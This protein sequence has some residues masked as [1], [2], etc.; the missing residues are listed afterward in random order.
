[1]YNL[2]PT[3]AGP[4]SR[5]HAHLDRIAAMGFDWIYLNPIHATGGSGSLYAVADYYRLNPRLRGDDPRGDDAIVAE[6]IAAA[7][8]HGLAVMLDLVI[9]H[10]ANDS[11]LVAEHPGWYAREADGSIAAP[12]AID[13]D[14]PENVTRWGDLAELDFSERPQR[15]EIV[16][17]FADVVRHYAGLGARGFRCDAA[18]KI[19]AAVWSDVI[20]AARERA[21]D[22]VFAAETL[23]ARLEEVAQLG[24]AGFDYLFNS[25]KWWDFRA[26]WLLEQYERFRHIAPSIAFPESHD[27]PRLAAELAGRGDAE[28]EAEYRFRYLFAAFFSSGVMMPMG[29]EFGFARK[30]DVVTTSPADW[31]DARFDLC[32]FI[33]AANALKADTPVL[34]E[35]GAERMLRGEGPAVTL[36]R[37][38]GASTGAAV[39]VFN[40]DASEPAEVDAR[41][42]IDALDGAPRDVTPQ[43]A[44]PRSTPDDRVSLQ[45]L[46]IRV[47]T[48]DEA[49]LDAAP[50]PRPDARAADRVVVIENVTPQI[51]GGRHPIKRIVGDRI[52][53]E[54]DVFRE[55][56]ASLAA[57]LLHRER[58]AAHWHETPLQPLGNDRWSG[59]FPVDRNAEY[60]YTI[61][62]WPDDFATWRREVSVKRAAGRPLALELEEGRALLRAARERAGAA[63]ARALDAL[64]R[65][66]TIDSLLAEETAAALA[67]V[68][69]RA[70][71][72]R[73]EPVLR[74]IA[75]RG[76]AQF[77]AW[78]EFFPRSQA[79]RPD[80]H[81][82]FADAARRLPEVRAMGF[83]VVYL[84][85]IHPIGRAFRKGRNN[86]TE[87]APGDPGSP[88]AI[89]SAD[90]G[91]TAVEPALGTLADFDAFVAAAHANG[92][93]VALDYALQASPD[94]PFLTEHPEWFTFRPDG[95]I[96]YA[97][98]PPK[99]YQDIVNFNW[100]GPHAPALW[101][102]LRDVI[103]FWSERGVRIFRVDNPHT[104]PFA[105]WEW[106][107]TDV[108]AR[109]PETIFLAE[110]F[111]R[112]A[113]MRQLA[114]LGF[115][116]S[117]TYFTWRNTKAEL[118]AYATE[119]SRSELA[120][121]FRPSFWPNT[122]DILPP[123]LQTGGR[124]AFR[125]RLIL[126]ATLA[127]N[128][129][130]Y[131][132]YELCENAALA[133]REEYANSE[134]YEIVSRDW[135]APGNIK[136]EIARVN[137]I[138]R[139]NRPLGDW[140]NL[141]FYRADDDA[142]LFYGK[143]SGDDTILVAV[144]LD[145]FA[146]RDPV[147]WLPTGDLGIADDEPYAVEE[148]LGATRHEWTGSPHRW[149]LDPAVNPAAIFRIKTGGRA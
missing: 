81:G 141:L 142:V 113:V 46:E 36:L 139:E 123:Y 28:I 97:E 135:N 44:A 106:L 68:P 105:F 1:V 43:G 126:A 30:L 24:G 143:R 146:A 18:Y 60:E 136:D 138:R 55:G 110:A 145:P 134:K 107:L 95:S 87:A 78:Y 88:W 111:T 49:P 42:L 84:P 122:P 115:S 93:E 137:R 23:G 14:V 34:N 35:E 16:R 119:L 47:F 71:A 121:Y 70:R 86:A 144:N 53:V 127:S 75:D 48:R 26:S 77:G 69:D 109:R 15:A 91:H 25:S 39:A 59:S 45:P 50:R 140:R 83:D 6:F 112:P 11:P 74:A 92:L 100:F 27:T 108:R 61:E 51:D 102:A 64:L 147:L 62:A 90:G 13:P 114:K 21:A 58:G 22:T 149:R 79:G 40:P 10:T 56:H 101:E 131:S 3:L 117:Y 8:E 73:Y 124:A 41:E 63:D 132:G 128:Y 96:K 133:G 12:C 125:I 5:W 80:V 72:T 54:A 20:A 118:T 89:G 33:A 57:V 98:N 9:N 130:I 94:H 66:A 148:L 67:R 17:F 103:L 19:P 104:K 82:T 2:F 120:E 52:E 31:E 29:Y 116:Q 129:G 65:N 32:S 4:V 7:R 38:G 37:Y 99:T 85:P 76:L